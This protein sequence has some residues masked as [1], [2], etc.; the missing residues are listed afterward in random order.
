MT[1]EVVF[2]PLYTYTHRHTCTH[3]CTPAHMCTCLTNCHRRA[4]THIHKSR[5]DWACLF[6]MALAHH[7]TGSFLGSVLH[8]SVTNQR[9]H[10]PAR[11]GE[12]LD[13]NKKFGEIVTPK[14]G[15]LRLGRSQEPSPLQPGKSYFFLP[16]WDL[17]KSLTLLFKNW[18]K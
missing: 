5:R 4:N 11:A 2:W 1:S 18:L 14:G 6:R 10:L 8:S 7:E 16:K 13:F 17:T 9:F 12:Q 3:M 15:V